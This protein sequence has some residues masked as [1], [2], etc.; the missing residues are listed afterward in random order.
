[1]VR[2]SESGGPARR[3]AASRSL[4]NFAF[5]GRIFV[6]FGPWFSPFWRESASLLSAV[7]YRLPTSPVG[8]NVR[9]VFVKVVTGL[10][11][12]ERSSMNLT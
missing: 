11:V 9:A 3:S 8:E 12:Q 2:S 6:T 5:A 10:S 4:T 7:L 1:M